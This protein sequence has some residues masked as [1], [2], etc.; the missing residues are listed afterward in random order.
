[1]SNEQKLILNEGEL[2]LLPAEII[3]S[4]PDQIREAGP[5][6]AEA[7]IEFFTA[8]I[9]NRNT[10]IAYQH[11]V[12]RFFVWCKCN[13]LATLSVI[14]PYHVGAYIE[15]LSRGSSK[16]TVKQHLAAIRM[17]F[18]FLVVGQVV[19]SN[20]AHSVRGPRYQ[21]LR[22]KTP[23]LTAAEARQLLDSIDTSTPIGI[24]DKAFI[25]CM[26]YTFARV[27]AVVGMDAIDCFYQSKR[28][29]LRL[30]E[31]GGRE[32]YLPTHHNLEVAMD[33][34]LL[35]LGQLEEKHAALFRTVNGLTGEY[36]CQRLSRQD[37]WKIMQRRAKAAGILTPIGN[38]T[39]RATGI[40]TYLENKGTLERARQMAAHCSVKTTMLYDR[41]SDDITLSE[42]ER[43]VI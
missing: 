32:L 26:L 16:P 18:D 5:K 19:E 41:R 15:T 13:D 39:C 42:V 8:K 34:Y 37:G 7:F 20:P 25:S 2:Q 4:L 10:R 14:R 35:A 31:K 11:A 12:R 3:A 33:N 21:I 30:Q 40:T 43:V 29:W 38:H 9:R 22:G 27:S 17:L 28:L 23:V 36:T 1:M 24:R 6:A